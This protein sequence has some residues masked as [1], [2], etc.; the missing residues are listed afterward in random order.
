MFFRGPVLILYYTLLCCFY[1][2]ALQIRRKLASNSENLFFFFVSNRKFTSTQNRI[3]TP[4]ASKPAD[5]HGSKLDDKCT[6]VTKTI[7]TITTFSTRKQTNSNSLSQ[8]VHEFER[9]ARYMIKKLNE[10]RGKIEAATSTDAVEHLK[11]T[12]APDAA[13]L[14]SQGDTLVLETHG[15]ASAELSNAVIDIQ[16][17]LREK[18]REVQHAKW[19]WKPLH[20]LPP[21][22]N[23]MKFNFF[24]DRTT[25]P[26]A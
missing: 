23:F 3:E 4:N 17:I 20:K 5:L 11:M 2:P 8:R 24:S 19:V 7:T 10:T 6:T 13:T 21:K 14:I 25:S 22:L 16:S 12:I 26:T 1:L 18:F 9:T 15:N